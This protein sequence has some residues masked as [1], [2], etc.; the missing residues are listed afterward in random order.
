MSSP[1]ILMQRFG[2]HTLGS[3]EPS[4]GPP[5][6]WIL[7]NPQVPLPGKGRFLVSLKMAQA[8]NL[9]GPPHCP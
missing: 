3:S 1:T 2:D 8:A 5:R 7:R 4:A 6:G 9:K